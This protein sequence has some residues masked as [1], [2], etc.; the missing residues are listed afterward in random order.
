MMRAVAVT[1]D[2]RDPQGLAQWWASALDAQVAHAEEGFA[3]V[4]SRPIE[5]AFQRVP[6]ERTGKNRTHVDFLAD[7]RGAVV[8][9]L[10]GQGA[11]VVGEHTAPGFAWTVLRDPEGNEFCVSEEVP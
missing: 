11:A 5:L 1:V 2:C 3:V 8:E 6:E 9:R 10:V 7:D 4:A